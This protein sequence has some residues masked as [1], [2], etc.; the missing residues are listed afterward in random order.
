MFRAVAE[1][2]HLSLAAASLGV[3]AS[4]VSRTL[5]LLETDLGV[6][7]LSHE[8]RGLRLTPAGDA[9]LSVVRN[10][11]RSI[12]EVLTRFHNEA[13][14][15]ML[16]VSI[17]GALDES[18][19][20]SALAL[21]VERYPEVNLKMVTT[22]A[23]EARS[24]LLAGHLDVAIVCGR[25]RP[26]G[27]D[28]IALGEQKV[29]IWAPPSW[30]L[31]AEGGFKRKLTWAALAK[32]PF[33]ALSSRYVDDPWPGNCARNVVLTTD[34]FAQARSAALATGSAVLLPPSM[35]AAD[36]QEG[37]LMPV[38]TPP[39]RAVQLCVVKRQALAVPTAAD[40]LVQWIVDVAP[41]ALN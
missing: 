39:L 29:R 27:I 34:T 2:E 28:V 5:S 30:R 24:A 41:R 14:S 26:D 25:P 12:D 35:A 20:A 18:F 17:T 40:V 21:M 37:R 13:Y 11:M 4:A 6:E 23:A 3:S 19:C 9:L 15:G 31:A 16:T 1:R 7:L 8:G 36:V 38:R 22:P 33:I 10:S 32:A